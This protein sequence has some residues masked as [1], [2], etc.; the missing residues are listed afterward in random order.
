MTERKHPPDILGEILSRSDSSLLQ[1]REA[2]DP[3][4]DLVSLTGSAVTCGACLLF[5]FAV[6]RW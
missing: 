4:K 1:A 3:A 5:A 6:E 2:I